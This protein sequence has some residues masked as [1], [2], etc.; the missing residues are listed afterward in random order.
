MKRTHTKEN[1]IK[2]REY[3]SAALKY[4]PYRMD[5]GKRKTRVE[6]GNIDNIDNAPRETSDSGDES[7][8]D[9][10]KESGE[11]DEMDG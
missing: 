8:E 9:S 10:D 6:P 1:D 7:N 4:A 5:G 3:I 2:I 11:S